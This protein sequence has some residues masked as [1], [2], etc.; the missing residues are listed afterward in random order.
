MT[1]MRIGERT[2]AWLCPLMVLGWLGFGGIALAEPLTAQAAVESDT[3]F[4]GQPFVFQIQV[5]GSDSLQE[6]D[7]S[8][9]VDFQVKNQG[10]QQN[11]SSSV[12]IIN[13]QMSKQV[14]R[15]YVFSYELTAKRVGLLDIPSITVRDGNAEAQTQPVR[16]TA[17]QPEQ[18]N[19][20]QLRMELSK[21]QAYVGEPVILDIIF[22]YKAQVEDTKLTMPALELPG[23]RFFDQEK[24]GAEN[25]ATLDGQTFQTLRLRKALIPEKSGDY[26]LPASTLSFQGVVG[27][28]TMQDWFFGPARR[29]EFKR[30]VIPSNELALRVLDLPSEGRPQHF[31]GLIGEYQIEAA[32]SPLNVNVGD[33]IT[34]TLRITGAEFPQQV[35]VPL[36]QKQPALVRDFRLPNETSSGKVDGKAVTFTQTIRA[37]RPEVREIPAIELPYF[38][39]NRKAYRIARSSPLPLEVRATRVVT[40]GDAVGNDPVSR[41]AKEIQEATG[42]I[43]YNYEDPDAL[44]NQGFEISSWLKSDAFWTLLLLPPGLYALLAFLVRR[45]RLNEADPEGVRERRAQVAFTKEIADANSPDAILSILR[46]YLR[47]KLRLPPGALTYRDVEPALKARGAA[48]QILED[49]LGV[50][51]ACERSRYAGVNAGD[52]AELARKSQSIVERIEAAKGRAKFPVLAR[53]LALLAAMLPGTTHGAL[54]PDEAQAMFREGNALF[55]EANETAPRD[56][57]AAEALYGKAILRFERL[58]R[59]GGIEN[60]KLYYN[61]GN[62][63]FRMNDLGRAI[64]NYRRAQELT[65]HD[66]NLARNLAYARQLC[67]DRIEVSNRRRV[68]EIFLFWHRDLTARTKAALFGWGAILAWVCLGVGLFRPAPYLW[69]TAV[70]CGALA[71]LMLGSLLVEARAHGSAIPGVV[72]AQEVVARKGDGMAYEPSFQ[73]PLHAGAEF[74]LV[75]SRPGWRLVELGDGRRCWLPEKSAEL[76]R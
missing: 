45:R 49:V 52:V 33:P 74:T 73:E 7:L 12:T 14:R 3:V 1:G 25:S 60:G 48:P 71:V 41:K 40:A 17:R 31:S 44:R 21:T 65:P 54:P 30:F 53:C 57:Q 43:A 23:L 55:R 76:V 16:I 50:F 20:F 35:T 66:A 13:G 6:P 51:E 19:E 72:V 63:Y 29:A 36:L 75:E 47:D 4:V 10:G 34:L 56:H 37:L 38:D 11:S 22:Y 15:G 8:G 62:A 39:P 64:L 9:L 2:L 32:A 58:I 68:A 42:G 5:S 24:P 28:R 27:F 67:T 46:G 61:V 26:K 18:T 69:R 70:G 59:E